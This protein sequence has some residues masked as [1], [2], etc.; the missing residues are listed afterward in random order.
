MDPQHF[1]LAGIR[2]GATPSTKPPPRRGER[3]VSSGLVMRGNR[4]CCFR[5]THPANKCR[6]GTLGWNHNL[7]TSGQS[8]KAVALQTPCAPFSPLPFLRCCD[9]K[10]TGAAQPKSYLDSSFPLDFEKPKKMDKRKQWVASFG[11]GHAVGAML[12]QQNRSM[13]ICKGTCCVKNKCSSETNE[14]GSF[15]KAT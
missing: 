14:S 5:S 11:E 3:R 10:Y 15:F 9:L 6:C 13:L 12:R 8:S 7:S 1:F 2:S 4:L